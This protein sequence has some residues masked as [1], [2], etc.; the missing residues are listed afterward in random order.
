MKDL[1]RQKIEEINHEL[2]S[3]DELPGLSLSVGVAFSDREQPTGD[4]YKDADTALYRA[5]TGGK[6]IC[7]FY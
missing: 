1:V 5:K 6:G 3:S 7:V 2:K 4:I